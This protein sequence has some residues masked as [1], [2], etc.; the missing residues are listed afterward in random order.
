M[1][2]QTNKYWFPRISDFSINQKVIQ[3]IHSCFSNRHAA[4]GH[5]GYKEWIDP[6]RF[7]VTVK[8][9]CLKRVK[10]GVSIWLVVL[11][12]A[13]CGCCKMVKILTKFCNLQSIFIIQSL[14]CLLAWQLILTI[15]EKH[16]QKGKLPISQ[17]CGQ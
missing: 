1:K 11:G 13:S 5:C 4:C 3:K 17:V 15:S 9:L 14:S 8:V 16:L 6:W 10:I 7:F 2:S 12:Y